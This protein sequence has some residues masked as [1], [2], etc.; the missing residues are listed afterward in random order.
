[1]AKHE[2]A[3]KRWGRTIPK[4]T[5]SFEYLLKNRGDHCFYIDRLPLTV[6]RENAYKFDQID[7]LYQE[8]IAGKTPKKE[9]EQI[10]KKYTGFATKCWL[11]NKTFASYDVNGIDFKKCKKALTLSNYS[12][13]V[14]RIS[15]TGY[16]EIVDKKDLDLWIQ[17]GVRDLSNAVIV[18]DEFRLMITAC[19]S[20]YIA[21]M[22]D[23]ENYSLV[24]DIAVSEGLFL[25]KVDPEMHKW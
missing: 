7:L 16:D 3:L 21:Y 10:E 1:M 9:F 19:W 14:K 15:N 25:R 20:C 11:Y 4:E 17:M 12:R 23:M 8:V 2:E 5:Y 13:L 6:K 18:F 22:D 24:K